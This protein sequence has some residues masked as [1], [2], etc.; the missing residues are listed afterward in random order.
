MS[1]EGALASMRTNELADSQHPHAQGESRRL[2]PDGLE[3][4]PDGQD[5][6]EVVQ[7]EKEVLHSSATAPH[8]DVKE[9]LIQPDETFT[10]QQ[11]GPR[12]RRICGLRP[13]SF[14]ILLAVGL[15]LAVGLGIGLGVG[16]SS[17]DSPS[18]SDD[19]PSATA[20]SAPTPSAS[21]QSRALIGGALNASYYS[22]RG[23]WNGSGLANNLQ[24]LGP[25]YENQPDNGQNL[26]MY[27]QHHSGDIR[28][29]RLASNARWLRGPEDREIVASDAKNSTGISAVNYNQ[30]GADVWHVFCKGPQPRILQISPKVCRVL[31]N[32][33][34]RY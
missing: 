31:A 10:P 18:N 7:P 4:V 9:P 15:V 19:S 17:G 24:T 20:T 2:I 32:A 16:L 28:W 23:A 5:G 22:D 12:K 29:Q 30:D 25:E 11:D 1:S 8:R 33:R 14:W 21:V 13:K 26:V 27:Y 3:V 6:K 34:H